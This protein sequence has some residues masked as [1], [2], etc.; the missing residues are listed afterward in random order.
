VGEL[1]RSDSRSGVANAHFDL[2]LGAIGFD[3]DR[4]PRRGEFD[5]VAYQIRKDLE[6]PVVITKDP[7]NHASL[8][9]FEPHVPLRG[10]RREE[11]HALANDVVELEPQTFQS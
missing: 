2:A 4:A 3:S 8:T 6:H 5:G 10:E 7:A 1:I 11:F 9:G